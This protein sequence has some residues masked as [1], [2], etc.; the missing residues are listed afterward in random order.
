MSAP[1]ELTK[2]TKDSGAVTKR[3]HLNPDG[4]IGNDSSRCAIGKGRMTRL[5]LPDWRDFKEMLE[6]TP[7]NTAY[8]LGALRPGLPD[9]VQ[10]VRKRD[11]QSAQPGVATR[12]ADAILYREKCPG[13]ALLDFDTKGMPPGVKTR[14]QD[15]GGFRGALGRVCPGFAAAGHIRRRSTSAGVINELTGE[16]YQ[17]D[18]QHLYVLVRDGA[19]AQRFLYALHDRCWLA[20]LGWHIVGQAGQLLERSIV[21]RAVCAPERL[22]F[23]ASPDLEPPLKQE[24][25]EATVHDGAPLD[26]MAA[27]ADLNAG[28]QA[29]LQRLQAAAAKVLGKEAESAR[30]AFVTEHVEKAIGRGM[31]PDK[32]RTMAEQWGKSILRPGVILEFDDLG[33]IPVAD[34]LADPG[35][36]DGETLAD[37][38]EGIGYGR[39]CAI[40]QVRDGIPSI[41]SFAHGGAIYK[42]RHD[43]ESVEA[44]ILAASGAEAAHVYSRMVFAADLDPV[45]KKL[46]A[47]LAAKRSGAGARRRG[48]RTAREAEGE[49]QWHRAGGARQRKARHQNRARRDP[50]HCR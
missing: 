40:V 48:S 35:R 25:R 8:A 1:V 17:S 5:H 43:F 47:K 27:C 2:I 16:S 23:E 21:D 37:P 12:T 33:A 24:K 26:T 4:S 14:L 20:G 29:E 15:L 38:I 11:P 45:E 13:F 46:L 28:E 31:D 3:V 50:P 32:A 6:A 19:A 44:A 49:R 36:F 22:V 41:F 42:L 10:L 9:S 30:K 39:N 7:R 34:I 18:G